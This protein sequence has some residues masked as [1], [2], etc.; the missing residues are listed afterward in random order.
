MNKYKNM[1]ILLYKELLYFFQVNSD[2]KTLYTPW[3]II[4]LLYYEY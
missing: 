2:M 3:Y 1:L 4:N